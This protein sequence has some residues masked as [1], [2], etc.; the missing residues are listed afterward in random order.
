MGTAGPPWLRPMIHCFF[1]L[2]L[3]HSYL[4]T[5]KNRRPKK[6]EVGSLV[7]RLANALMRCGQM[8]VK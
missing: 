3:S 7:C 6:S 8:N 4:I 5:L 1:S 2:A